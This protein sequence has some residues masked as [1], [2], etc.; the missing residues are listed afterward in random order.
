MVELEAYSCKNYNLPKEHY[1]DSTLY[2][3]I[4]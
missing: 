4:G 3:E 2:R 1:G